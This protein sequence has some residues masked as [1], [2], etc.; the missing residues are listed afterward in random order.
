[1]NRNINKFALIG[2]LIVLAMAMQT[3]INAQQLLLNEIEIDPPS[4][5]N[6]ACQYTEVRGTPGAVV[7]PNT[8]FISVNSDGANFGFANQVVNFG[9]QTIGTNGTL[10]LFNTSGGLCQN[11]TF[12][13]GTTVFNYFLALTVGTGSETYLIV[14]STTPLASGSDLDVNDDFLL[15]PNFGITVLD[16][17][18][19]LVNPEEEPVYGASAGAVNIS[20]TTSI[21]QPDAVTR[22]SNNANPFVGAA[23]YFGELAASPDE[24]T[25][26]AA[27][28]SR[29]FPA[30]GAL[31]PGAPSVGNVNVNLNKTRADFDGDGRTD[32]SV[33]RSSNGIW[34][35]NRST[36]GFGGIQFGQAG[37][38]IVPGD[39]DNDN[40]AD[41]A[42]RRGQIW[43]ILNSSN[44]TVTQLQFGL[45]S[46]IPVPADYD[47]D[48]DTDIAVFRPSNG[49]WY[50]S[51][52]PANNYG[53]VQFGQSGDVPTPGD[54]D[55]DGR[56]DLAVYRNGTWFLNQTTAGRRAVI[57]GFASDLPVPAD[58]DG[59]GRD[60]IAVFRPSNGFWYSLRSA[61]N[62]VSSVRFGQSG[63]VP[64]PGDYDGD[65]RDDQAVFRG[66]TWFLN[67]STAGQLAVQFGASSDKPVPNA[68]LP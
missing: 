45:E 18:A 8:S 34:Y 1:M 21:D 49:T 63:D 4:T 51:T 15:D 17:F 10:V 11:R 28:L 25:Q 23:F 68:Y 59:D 5:T 30:G 54:Y 44:L 3:K 55:G 48:G 56:T 31:T 42:V 53:A 22:F 57:F 38:V 37:D 46:D 20:N 19:L 16:G 13:T 60:D 14:R 39:Y 7:P 36:A 27:P 50:T 35:F 52:S 67:R 61:D 2:I 12:P 24:T 58:Y 6:N 43:Y 40:R 65:G 66:G 9:G 26:Y 47:S 33:F 32:L 64:V 62:T 41:T 29:N